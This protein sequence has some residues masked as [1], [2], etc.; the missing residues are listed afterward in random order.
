VEIVDLELDLV[1]EVFKVVNTF[2]DEIELILV[3]PNFDKD[4]ELF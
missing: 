3:G 4:L 1:K 2:K